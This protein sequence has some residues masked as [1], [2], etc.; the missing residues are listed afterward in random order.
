MENRWRFV[1]PVTGVVLETN[2]FRFLLER[3][4]F[5]YGICVP[6]TFILLGESAPTLVWYTTQPKYAGKRLEI[7]RLHP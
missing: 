5:D 1:D 2:D 7:E 3:I 6:E 4:V